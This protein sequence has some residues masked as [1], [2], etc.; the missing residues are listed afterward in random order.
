LGY[1]LPYVAETLIGL[2]EWNVDPEERAL[3]LVEGNTTAERSDLIAKTGLALRETGHFK[4]LAGWRNELYPVYGPGGE[5]LFDMERALSCLFGIVTY[6]SHMT[7][8]TRGAEDGTIKF[9][10]PRRSYSKSTYPGILDNTVAGG[11][12]T[13]EVPF[14]CIVREAEEEASLPEAY[15]RPNVK[16][17]GVVSYFHIRGSRAGGESDFLQPEV[18]YL[19]EL[20]VPNDMIPK[21]CDGEVEEFYLWSIDELKV[22]LGRNEFKPNCAVVLIDFMIRHNIITPEN[23]K[24]YL[25]ISCRLHRKLVFPTGLL[26][27]EK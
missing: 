1:V 5:L 3:T 8:Y 17:V 20:E 27:H 11:L 24:D 22:A 10:V 2:P 14:E 19:Y 9:W 21:P 15:V 16:A 26:F 23:E 13:G 6:G 18:E 12:A 4:V 25:D 7:A